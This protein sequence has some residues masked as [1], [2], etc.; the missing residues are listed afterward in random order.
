MFLLVVPCYIPAIIGIIYLKKSSLSRFRRFIQT[1]HRLFGSW[2]AACGWWGK[3][4][5][6]SGRGPGSLGSQPSFYHCGK[7]GGGRKSSGKTKKKTFFFL[8]RM[9]SGFFSN[10]T[11]GSS[12]S[13]TISGPLSIYEIWNSNRYNIWKQCSIQCWAWVLAGLLNDWR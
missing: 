3:L 12:T 8:H 7:T 5:P 2:S 6:S 13:Q 10:V 9:S 1:N 11:A 4:W